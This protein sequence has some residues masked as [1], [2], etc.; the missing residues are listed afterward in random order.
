MFATP[1]RNLVFDLNDFDETLPG[2]WEWDVKRLAASFVLAGRHRGFDATHEPARRHVAVRTYG[3][4]LREFAAMGNLDVWYSR[5]DVDML[6]QS[7]TAE[8]RKQL[9]RGVEKARLTRPPTGPGQAHG[10][11]RRCAPHQGR[12]TAHRAGRP[13]T[14]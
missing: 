2:P 5:I 4:R 3:L 12:P 13:A 7:A 1:E 6:Y 8:T 14:G 10:G 9:E 11:G